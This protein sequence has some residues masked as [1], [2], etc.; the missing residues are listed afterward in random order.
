[1]DTSHV[2]N[3]FCEDVASQSAEDHVGED[4][5]LAVEDKEKWFR[6]HWA[7]FVC[8]PSKSQ[9]GVLRSL[10]FLSFNFAT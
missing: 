1:M 2:S 8:V 5:L 9:N 6:C 3:L 10:L 4:E 7:S